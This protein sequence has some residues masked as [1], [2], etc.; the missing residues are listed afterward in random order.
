MENYK[1]T[2][3]LLLTDIVLPEV[4]GRE[5]SEMVTALFPEM[6]VLFMS[7]YTDNAIVHHG[8]LIEGVNYLQKP[9]TM[10]SLAQKVRAV[11]DEEMKN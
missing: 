9:F 2:I 11:L 1:D 8:V 6:K 3:H 4:S 10:R 7:G 5:L